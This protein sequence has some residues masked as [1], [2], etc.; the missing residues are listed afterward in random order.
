MTGWAVLGGALAALWI[1]DGLR[2]RQRAR[3]FPVLADGAE[4]PRV[5]EDHVFVVRPGVV[6]D[7][8]TRRAASAHAREN[9]LDVL[10]LVAPSIESW[11]ALL[12]LLAVDPA[13]FR[14]D[15][16][17][18]GFSPA[19]AILVRASTLER[20]GATPE[21]RNAVAMVELSRSLKL[22]AAT[23]TDFAIAPALTSPAVTMRERRRL[24]RLLFGDMVVPLFVLQLAL[25]ASTIAFAPT[26][27]LAALAIFHLQVL[28]VTV[29]TP[30]AP[31]GRLAHAALRPIVDLAS[32]VG[33]V[34]PAPPS[35]V[36]AAELRPVYDELLACG[37]SAF[38]E[39]PREDCP[40]CASRELSK[41]GEFPDHYQR[42][43]G[44]FVLSRCL[45]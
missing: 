39:P 22:H 40:L 35:R 37:T 19:D 12:L 32:T 3:S 11:R 21:P 14:R 4:R 8:G 10:D 25:L 28:L 7:D 36:S 13:R 9:D 41:L 24:L 45:G 23:A 26:W 44:R 33:P 34:A 15:R 1:A 42:K 18:R 16:F 29:G 5:A 43:P 20:I 30:L 38:F 31:S 17:A 2:L 27:G 6:L